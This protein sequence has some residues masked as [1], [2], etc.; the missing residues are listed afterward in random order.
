[1]TCQICTEEFNKSTR[2]Q[3]QC[4][5][6]REIFCTA[7]VK[8]YIT[9]YECVCLSCK[10]EWDF[11]FLSENL[12]QKFMR[13]EYREMKK[14]KLFDL[15]TALLP[16]T[17]YF[18]DLVKKKDKLMT[19]RTKIMGRVNEL[20]EIIRKH[21]EEISYIQDEINVYD[22][23]IYGKKI[24]HYKIE[25]TGACPKNECRGFIRRCDS[26]C[27]ICETKICKDC[28][29]ILDSSDHTCKEENIESAKLIQK[30]SRP[31]PKCAALIFK[32]DGC[33]QM[34]CVLCQTA[35]SWKTGEIETGRIH[36]PHYYDWLRS[37]TNGDIPREPVDDPTTQCDQL[38]D[39][40]QLSCW[41][42][43]RKVEKM[44]SD[45]H[46]RT[47][48][49]IYNDLPTLTQTES[50]KYLRIKYLLGDISK[51]NFESEIEKKD[52]NEKKKIAIFHCLDLYCR[53]MKENFI[54]V[55]RFL[56]NSRRH[57]DWS[58][59]FED[60]FEEYNLIVKFTNENLDKVSN[61]HKC[62]VQKY[63]ISP[64]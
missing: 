33:D 31:C 20:E 38:I 60:F 52:R 3:L 21:R 11:D 62:G 2:K 18:V 7:C 49:I 12:S 61:I 1:M 39:Y 36:N 45:I 27:G 58:S 42:V 35:F 14:K 13:E 40:G 28:R 57:M 56:R 53:I 29:E 64:L 8:K 9:E 51:E 41:I 19:E 48:H 59:F 5:K 6:C 23:E 30:D 50:N 10:G 25:F 44:V 26:T 34:F 24:K 22:S 47:T 43:D 17:M 16:D 32:I 54:K 63:K 46:R 55:Y 15:E 37:R 4:P